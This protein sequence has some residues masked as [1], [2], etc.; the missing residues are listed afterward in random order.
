MK[1][2]TYDYN[3]VDIDVDLDDPSILAASMSVISG[4][5]VLSVLYRDGSELEYDACRL[6]GM[7]RTSDH[8]D[9]LYM[10]VINGNWVVDKDAFLSRKDSYWNAWDD[11]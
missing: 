3:S 9:G 1:L 8:Y 5:E 2:L 11:E 7:L 6:A 10:V 4:D